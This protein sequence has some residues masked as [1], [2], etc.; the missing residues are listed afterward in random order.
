MHF[1]SSDVESYMN[2]YDV[3]EEYAIELIYKQI[4]DTWKDISH[5]FLTCKDIPITL[6]TCM[7]NL[8]RVIDVL[9]K[10]KDHFTDVSE[11]LKDHIR[12]IFVHSSYEHI[13]FSLSCRVAV[14]TLDKC[15]SIFLIMFDCVQ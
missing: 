6:R 14:D 11:E 8:T 5:E 4:E 10:H 9:Y 7:I 1:A 15:S 3:T 2:I 13:S 12:S